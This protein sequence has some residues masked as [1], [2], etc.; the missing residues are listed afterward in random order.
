[1]E[2]SRDLRIDLLR[3]YF[4]VAMIVDH[5]RGESP[6]YLLTGG[7][8]FFTSAAEGFIFTS[9]LVAGL[10]YARLIARDGMQRSFI[11]LLTRAATLYLLTVGVTLLL[12][13]LSEILYLPWA[14]GVDLTQYLTV[15][16]SILT[17]H[18]TYYLIDVMLLYTVL[19]ALVPTVL[20]LLQ[21]GKGLVVLGL[22]WGIWALYQ[23]CPECAAMPW[24]IAGNYLF[25]FSAWQVLF[26]TGLVLGF[27]R[28]QL[29]AL[30]GRSARLALVIAALAML[31][32]VGA[33]FV[34]DPPIAETPPDIQIGSLV[35]Y[36]ARAWLQDM[37][38]SKVSLRPGRLL[39][40]AIVF[41]FLFFAVSLFW[42][43]VQRVLG[44]LLLPLG[45]HAL[46]AYTAHIVMAAVV[47]IALAPLNLAYPGPQWLNA[48]IQVAS[49][50]LIWY[51]AQRQFLAPNAATQR[52]WN[53]SPVGIFLLAALVLAWYPTPAHPGI[54]DPTVSAG[55]LDRAPRRFGTPAPPAPPKV[56]Q[57][58]VTPT[59]LP[60]APATVPASPTATPVKATATA[61]PTESVATP[62]RAP[63]AP[64][65]V[66]TAPARANALSTALAM[67]SR[68]PSR[69]LL[70][71][72]PLTVTPEPRPA[73]TTDL[74]A[75]LSQYLEPNL[76]GTLGEAWFYSSELDLDMP[77]LYY[78]PPDYNTAGR[79]Y[80]VLY[81]LH[82][83]GGH[84]D[85]WV[86]YGLI[87]AADREMRTGS[88]PPMII[89]LP[90][91]DTS[92]WVNHFGDEQRW[93]EYVT[94]DLVAHTDTAYRTLRSPAARAIGGISM[95]GSGALTNAFTHP[96]VFGVVGAHSPS[97]REDDG[98][99][100]F[101]GRGADY[102]SLDP[103]SL[104][105]KVAI[106]ASLQI[107]LDVGVADQ[108]LARTTLLHDTLAKRGIQHT[109][110]VYPGDH[111][112]P[113]WEAHAVDYVR[114]YGRTL[115]PR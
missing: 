52:Y 18:R 100:P 5:V 61:R 57:V 20:V 62:V 95:G 10:V 54:I 26:F 9:G 55:A 101:L 68:R 31:L 77:Y 17:L 2:K 28:N 13:P 79:R 69:P 6:L 42:R 83:A 103:I 11:R 41:P 89:I 80:P 3:G 92:Y 90:Q 114:Y 105:G 84:R 12:L 32:L 106:P 38:F 22:S 96:D 39:S 43:P 104:A 65:Q 66:S 49:V 4:V 7:N 115:S 75:R 70:P 48:A 63:S 76:R 37:V 59:A 85:E 23:V 91:G 60:A 67:P 64:S 36:D 51:L 98:E 93:G 56:S 88:T 1:M 53:A 112:G 8:R 99:V 102:A 94:H 71:T 87:N 27:H 86:A 46:Y 97:L 111:T 29:P 24:A 40:S 78:L 58:V 19:F 73:P 34:I 50:L 108:W 110:H 15:L 25:E 113:Y 33:F 109:W 44:W 14:Q 21:E 74:R 47:A 107:W 72:A 35:F 81:M 16:V 45:Q 30:T 82:G